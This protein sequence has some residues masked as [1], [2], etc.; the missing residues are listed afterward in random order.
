VTAE[1]PRQGAKVDAATVERVAKL[2]RLELADSERDALVTDLQRILSYI[3][4]LEAIDTANV[5]PM[6]HTTSDTAPLR[7]DTAEPALG[8]EAALENAP[9]RAGGCFVVPRVVGG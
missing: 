8:T 6:I 9:A 3:D 5:E 7:Q 2:A 4:Q 1:R